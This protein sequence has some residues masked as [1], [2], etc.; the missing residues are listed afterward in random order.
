[1]V[2]SVSRAPDATGS[3][4]PAVHSLPTNTRMASTKLTT[5]LT[6][7]ST[8]IRRAPCKSIITRRTTNRLTRTPSDKAE[9]N[10]QQSPTLHT[11]A[12]KN[13]QTKIMRRT[14][15]RAVARKLNQS[16]ITRHTQPAAKLPSNK[17][18]RP[19]NTSPANKITRKSLTANR[20]RLLA[21]N[22]ASNRS[23]NHTT[24]SPNPHSLTSTHSATC[25][26]HDTLLQNTDTHSNSS[27]LTR[28]VQ[29]GT[30]HSSDAAT[31]FP[32]CVLVTMYDS[33]LQQSRRQSHRHRNYSLEFSDDSVPM[34]C[35]LM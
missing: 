5:A 27:T 11:H 33:A 19:S 12:S 18:A 14:R 15:T 7:Q 28:S 2:E 16:S 4:N 24:S 32:L 9:C 13:N 10:D 31:S 29:S 25:N 6:A 26:S 34:D 23:T 3:S 30:N 8:N 17:L 21:N 20:K 35:L 22:T 1:M